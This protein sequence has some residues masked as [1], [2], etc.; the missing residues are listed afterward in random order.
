MYQRVILRCL[1]GRFLP[2]TAKLKLAFAVPLNAL[3]AR[4]PLTT[5][6]NVLVATTSNPPHVSHVHLIVQLAQTPQ[7][8][9][10]AL[11]L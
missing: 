5:A 3:P 7:I 9:H 10:P 8:A 6:Q 1:E 2:E 11:L 4:N